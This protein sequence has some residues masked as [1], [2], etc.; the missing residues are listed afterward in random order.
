[1]ILKHFLPAIILISLIAC[2]N[3]SFIE[4]TTDSTSKVI[5]S[6]KYVTRDSV[7]RK[8]DSNKRIIDS[9][10]SVLKDSLKSVK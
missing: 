5:D 1:M 4:K 10:F 3:K 6:Q 9:T 7:T 8:A 2:N